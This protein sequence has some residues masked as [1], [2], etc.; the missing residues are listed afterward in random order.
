LQQ[1]EEIEQ[2]RLKTENSKWR[3]F[4]PLGNQATPWFLGMFIGKTPENCAY[5][6]PGWKLIPETSIRTTNMRCDGSFQ[7]EVAVDCS[8]LKMATRDILSAKRWPEK[9]YGWA[10]PTTSSSI[11]SV[12]SSQIAKQL[13]IAELCDNIIQRD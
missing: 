11:S 3:T 2:E 7:G 1:A 8:T 12:G 4:N 13:M 10:L 5:Y 9:W 6:W